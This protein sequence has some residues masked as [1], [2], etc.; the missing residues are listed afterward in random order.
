MTSGAPR[1]IVTI[2]KLV[3]LVPQFPCVAVTGPERSGT[4]IATEMICSS[5]GYMNVSEEAWDND[6]GL[7]WRLLCKGDGIVVHAPHLTFRVHEIDRHCP[8]RV[9]IVF[10]L[11]AVADI[12]ASQRNCH[13][14][15]RSEH[16]ADNGDP[17]GWGNPASRWYDAASH[18]MFRDVIEPEAHLCLNRQRVWHRRQKQLVSNYVEVEYETLRSHWLWLEPEKRLRG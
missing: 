18:E 14:G 1:G 3:E 5:T 11:R 17:K 7:L 12:V 8:E 2:E 4:T 16:S 15:A 9:L 13:W 10:M 6:F